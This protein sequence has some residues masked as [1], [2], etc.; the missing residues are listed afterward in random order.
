VAMSDM[1]AVIRSHPD[2]QAP[3]SMIKA[4]RAVLTS[5]GGAPAEGL[6]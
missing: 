6:N 3:A 1:A 4:I 5:H 2:Y